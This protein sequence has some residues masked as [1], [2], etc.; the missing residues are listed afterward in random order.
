[1]DVPCSGL[2]ALRRRPESRW[3]RQ[4][5]DLEALVSLQ[6]A[7]LASA[8]TSVRIGG[9]VTYVTCSPHPA[10]TRGVVDSVLRGQSDVQELDARVALPGV[11]DLGPGPHAQ[12]WP[13]L[14]GTDAMFIAQLRR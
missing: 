4:P 14:H 8:L 3:R 7:L 5:Q 1:V 6:E 9:V 2:G 10:E 11:P 13:H 12:L